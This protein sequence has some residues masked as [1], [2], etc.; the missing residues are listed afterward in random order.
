LRSSPATPTL[1]DDTGAGDREPADAAGAKPAAHHDALGI[2]PGLELE[3]AADDERQLLREILDRPLQH[4]RRVGVPFGH[5]R[6]QLFLAYLLA[7]LVAERILAIPAQRLAPFLQDVPKG[8]LA[9]AV[10]EKAVLVL[11]FDV[12]AVDLHRGQMGGAVGGQ[13]RRRCS[14][15]I[16]HDDPS[17]G[18]LITVQG[19]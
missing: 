15:L 7:R 8:A 2:A 19:R 12:V 13:G 4:A 10:A 11:R 18:G 3:E 5:E 16:G 9:G 14:G 1:E 17:C 6:I